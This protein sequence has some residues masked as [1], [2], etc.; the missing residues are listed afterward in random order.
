MILETFIE[1]TTRDEEICRSVLEAVEPDNREAPKNIS[2]E[3]MCKNNVLYIHVKGVDV[4]ILTFRNTVDDLLEH[5][6]IAIKTLTSVK[7]GESCSKT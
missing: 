6:S 1:I 5:I 2:I 4:P 3:M 7:P